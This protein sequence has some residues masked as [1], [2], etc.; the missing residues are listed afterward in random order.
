MMLLIFWQYNSGA[1]DMLITEKNLKEISKNIK[2]LVCNGE[3][4]YDSSSSFALAMRSFIMDRLSQGYSQEDVFRQIRD[5]YGE[6]IIM[7]P[8][9]I[10]YNIVLWTA[11][12]ILL[13]AG[14]V[15]IYYTVNKAN[16]ANSL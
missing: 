15:W 13:I 7:T 8:S 5:I 1:N 4:V 12:V 3:S 11:P 10:G 14:C 16:I 2:C 9:L 6:Q